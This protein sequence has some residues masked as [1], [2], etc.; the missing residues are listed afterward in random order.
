MLK[1]K[2]AT[3]HA[4]PARAP[5]PLGQKRLYLDKA[6]FADYFNKYKE[7]C[8]TETFKKKLHRDSNADLES[9]ASSM[10]SLAEYEA[11]HTSVAIS[12]EDAILPS[13]FG[14]AYLQSV[15]YRQHK[16]DKYFMFP[17][18]GVHE[19]C[20]QTPADEPLLSLQGKSKTRIGHSVGKEAVKCEL[21][22]PNKKVK[23]VSEEGPRSEKAGFCINEIL[24][25]DLGKR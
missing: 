16:G 12:T 17:A 13:C 4:T 24:R 23:V 1:V 21:E 14:P 5:P 2:T 8:A 11:K 22:E 3:K 18:Y 7:T 10:P 25:D 15:Q 20:A 9:S 6:I 19:E